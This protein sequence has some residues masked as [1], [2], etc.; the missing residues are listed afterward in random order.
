MK[1]TVT[2]S[3]Q[4][5]INAKRAAKRGT[6][7][8]KSLAK[9]RELARE[10]RRTHP[11]RLSKHWKTVLIFEL[12]WASN[13]LSEYDDV[14]K[15]L[16]KLHRKATKLICRT[17]EFEGAYETI[18]AILDMYMSLTNQIVWV[19]KQQHWLRTTL[20]LYRAILKHDDERARSKHN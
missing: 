11:R 4:I 5:K 8:Y 12:M 19:N 6:K 7:V 1:H 18:D 2:K 3:Q 15:S 16:L 20:D 10:Y 13:D 14:R 9:D 17:Y